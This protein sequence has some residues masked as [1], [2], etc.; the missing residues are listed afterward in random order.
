MPDNDAE[1]TVHHGGILANDD[2]YVLQARQRRSATGFLEIVKDNSDGMRNPVGQGVS[3]TV[4]PVSPRT[5]PT[6]REARVALQRAAGAWSGDEKE[7]DRYLEW[8]RQQRKGSR[9]EISE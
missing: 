1:P 9:P 5:S 2:Y 4:E 8:N 6:S 3:V 7:L